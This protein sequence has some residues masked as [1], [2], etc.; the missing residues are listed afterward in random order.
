M[1]NKL[2]RHFHCVVVDDIG[3]H[4]LND[5]PTLDEFRKFI[6]PWMV[7][8]C[9]ETDRVVCHTSSV[10]EGIDYFEE[11]ITLLRKMD[12][13]CYWECFYVEAPD[14]GAAVHRIQEG[15]MYEIY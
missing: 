14:L 4:P 5:I 9:V 3:S 1:D 6:S 11:A 10:Q 13:P 15:E 2:E 8:Y 7:I 12:I